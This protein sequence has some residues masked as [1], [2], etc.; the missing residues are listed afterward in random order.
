MIC[1]G[2]VLG[3]DLLCCVCDACF[4]II[5][6]VWRIACWEGVETRPLAVVD[7]SLWERLS[8]GGYC[9]LSTRETGGETSLSMVCD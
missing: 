9:E 5:S 8:V 4:G 3:T 6:L 7:L 2:E 1:G